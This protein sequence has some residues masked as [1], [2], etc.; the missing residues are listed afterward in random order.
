MS[1][2]HCCGSMSGYV[3]SC[4]IIFFNINTLRLRLLQ[5]YSKIIDLYLKTTTLT[6]L[7][8]GNNSP[9]RQGDNLL[10]L[11]RRVAVLLQHEMLLN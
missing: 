8:L 1:A 10:Y 5:K 11:S 7:P 3:R 4:I 9:Q 2:C 6:T